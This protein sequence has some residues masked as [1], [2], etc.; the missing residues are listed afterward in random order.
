MMTEKDKKA[1]AKR[2]KP[3]IIEAIAGKV[4]EVYRE[5]PPRSIA[6]ILRSQVGKRGSYLAVL[7][8][9]KSSMSAP[10]D[11]IYR[12]ERTNGTY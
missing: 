12:T 3:S 9:L 1:K 11:D 7:E 10:L 5:D 8:H 6:A 2:P 4:E